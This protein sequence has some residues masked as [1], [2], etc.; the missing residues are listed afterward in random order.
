MYA[1]QFNQSITHLSNYFMIYL[2]NVDHTIRICHPDI[3]VHITILC[4]LPFYGAQTQDLPDHCLSK[5]KIYLYG[6]NNV[7]V[8]KCVRPILSK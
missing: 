4:Y 1:I 3:N 2:F 8:L 5:L 6:L 7:N